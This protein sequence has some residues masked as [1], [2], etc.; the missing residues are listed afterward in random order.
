[1]H[2]IITHAVLSTSRTNPTWPIIN[3]R[4]IHHCKFHTLKHGLAF[5]L[6]AVQMRLYLLLARF[7]DPTRLVLDA[8]SVHQ[9]SP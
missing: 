3:N 5:L 6:L 4:L 8:W 1:M 9:F 7:E 2:S